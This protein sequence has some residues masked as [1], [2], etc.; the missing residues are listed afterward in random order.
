M[1]INKNDINDINRTLR[2]II[3][4]HNMHYKYDLKINVS[5][6]VKNLGIGNLR[7]SNIRTLIIYIYMLQTYNVCLEKGSDQLIV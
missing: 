1:N 7:V 4:D 2:F 3:V 6:S 5:L